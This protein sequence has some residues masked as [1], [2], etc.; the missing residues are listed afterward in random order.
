[1]LAGIGLSQAVVEG[2]LLR[3]GSARL[4]E[5][6][7]AVLGYVCGA[8]GYGTLALA[9]AGWSMVPAAALIALAGLATPSVRTMVSRQGEADTQGE[10]QSVLAAV[11]GLTAIVAPLLTAGLFWAFTSH[12]VL[13]VFPWVPLALVAAF[14]AVACVLLR[15]LA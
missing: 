9:L 15:T 13:L 7:T 2:F 5:R 6:R 1:M 14:A 10:M 8:V 12:A 4:G 11:E 3:Y